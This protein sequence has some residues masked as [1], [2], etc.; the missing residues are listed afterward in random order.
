MRIIHYLARMR[1]EDGGVVRAMLD[2]I[3][4]RGFDWGGAVERSRA[5]Y[6]A[7]YTAV[8]ALLERV[9]ARHGWFVLYDLHTYNHRRDGSDAPPA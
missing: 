4:D 6:D 1:L 5:G 7:F 2:I 8:D 9:L 3:N